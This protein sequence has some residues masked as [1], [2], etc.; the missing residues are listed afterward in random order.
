MSEGK[1]GEREDGVDPGGDGSG[2]PPGGEGHLQRAQC[3]HRGQEGL[4][5]AQP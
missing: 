2:E 3:G 4:H 1:E 5:S